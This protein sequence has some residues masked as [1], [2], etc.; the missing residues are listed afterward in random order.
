MKRS[1]SSSKSVTNS[2]ILPL[3]SNFE[4]SL[5]IDSKR[6]SLL[7]LKDLNNTTLTWYTSV[8]NM[9]LNIPQIVKVT[10]MRKLKRN[11]RWK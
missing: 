2:M 9:I 7:T 8:R 11:K 10:K 6:R 3:K 5:R 1:R 4:L